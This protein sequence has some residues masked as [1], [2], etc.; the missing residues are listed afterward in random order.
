M[1]K[2][3]LS[4]LTIAVLYTSSTI[5][6]K[7]NF[8]SE[9]RDYILNKGDSKHLENIDFATVYPKALWKKSY[10]G[11]IL[12]GTAVIGAGAFSYFTAGA[13]A[14]AAATGVGSVAAW[15]GGGSGY[16]AGLSTIGS[17]FGGNAI[18]GAA[19]LNG[20]SIGAI[21]GGLGAKVATMSILAKIGMGV[22]VT[23]LGLDGIAYFKNPETNQMEYGV[24]VII[25]RDIGSQKV[26]DIVDKIY[27][28]EDKKQEDRE[29]QEDLKEDMYA[30]EKNNNYK[31]YLK[32]KKRLEKKIGAEKSRFEDIEKYK[33]EAI[34]ILKN[35]RSLTLNQE[36]LLVLS[37]IA[38]DQREYDLFD[39]TL[40]EINRSKLDKTG[41]L[42]YLDALNSLYHGNEVG[43]LSYLQSAM[44]SDK[45][46]LE[47][48]ALSINILGYGNFSKNELKIE[49]LVKFAE[50]NFESNNYISPL[51]MVSI[52][53]RVGT[54]YFLN[55]RYVKAREY[56]KKAEDKLGYFQKHL[57]A[58]QLKHTIELSI[59]NSAY[60][61]GKID[62]ANN[63]YKKIIKDIDEEDINEIKKIK[64][65][66][67]GNHI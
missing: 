65:L 32:L 66:Y 16:M 55:H 47:P 60:K 4:I 62:T 34:N 15:V 53:Y 29:E 49:N 11:W 13:G 23:A 48:V 35:R 41:F 19:V 1:K 64:A 9:T 22:S 44:D 59:A 67:L 7:A 25:P 43:S 10:F 12:T 56:Y 51:S 6:A 5:T 39:I 37:I 57:F 26:K 36:D 50:D 33:N 58:K 18:I 40:S 8:W 38:A 3:T 27:E 2:I 63:L 24:R 20:L 30:A 31:K 54:L 61:E 42:Y 28:A 21:G 46:A 14:P 17:W 45:Y 52:Y